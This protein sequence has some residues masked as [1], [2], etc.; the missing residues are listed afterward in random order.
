LSKGFFDFHRKL[1][2]NRPIYFPLASERKSFIAFI[3]IHRWVDETL[4]VLL[5]DH[6][7]PTRKRL[8]GALADLRTV[9]ASEANRANRVRA[10]K[11]FAEAQGLLEEL[12]AFID[13]VAE[14][15]DHGPPPSDE[16]TKKREVDIRFAMDLNDGVMVNSA[17]LWPLLEPMWKDPRK[18]WKQLANTEGKKDYDWSHQAARYFPNRVRKKCQDDPSL[19]VAHACFWELHPAKAYAW[20]LRLQDEIEPGFTIDEPSSD[21]ARMK[22]VTEHVEEAKEILVAEMKRR[23]RKTAKVDDQEELFDAPTEEED[24]RATDE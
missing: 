20:E 9:K 15:A 8:E 23:E 6:L 21:T 11:R 18:W 16:K 2:E 3:S 19:A 13:R 22:F 14:I 12:N 7:M 10:E 5:A 1:Y 4:N 17:A 24:Q